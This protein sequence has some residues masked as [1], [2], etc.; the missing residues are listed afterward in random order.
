MGKHVQ[1]PKQCEICLESLN[2]EMDWK[3]H[4]MRHAVNKE[5]L[6]Y[7]CAVEGCSFRSLQRPN[8]GQ[9]YLS[10]HTDIMPMVAC[11]LEVV[12][13][14]GNRST[15]SYSTIH[16]SMMCKHRKRV[17]GLS[18]TQNHR[19]PGRRRSTCTEP[20]DQAEVN[21]VSEPITSSRETRQET[22]SVIAPG[23]PLQY[24]AICE[25]YTTRMLCNCGSHSHHCSRRSQPLMHHPE[26]ACRRTANFSPPCRTRTGPE[27]RPR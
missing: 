27:G 7:R 8:V 11:Q 5:D 24:T 18:A 21:G 12:D 26:E 4:M 9:H 25:R 14:N 16:P 10:Q 23:R 3:R 19:G 2:R 20:S 1:G 17:H 22:R 13:E 6:M 15:C